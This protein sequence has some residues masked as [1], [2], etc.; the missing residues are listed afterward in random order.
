MRAL[1]NSEILAV[2]KILLES[3]AMRKD[4]MLPILDKLVSCCVPERNKKAIQNLL[5][6]KKYHYIEPHHHR[7]VLVGLWELGQ[8]VQSQQI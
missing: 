7:P 2:C 5:S 8:A 1:E 4:E 3:R 6:N